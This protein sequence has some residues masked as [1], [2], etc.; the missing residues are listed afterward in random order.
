MALVWTGAVTTGAIR[1]GA[2][3]L[4]PSGH[5]FLGF[6][7][8]LYTVIKAVDYPILYD[9]Y[10][11]VIFYPSALMLYGNSEHVAH[12]WSKIGLIRK[13]CQ[14]YDCCLAKLMP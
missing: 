13:E 1:A 9:L 10:Y 5:Y 11:R 7:C 8:S 14:I 12:V 2:H 3:P 6:F 4:P